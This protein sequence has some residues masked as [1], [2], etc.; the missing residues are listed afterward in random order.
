MTQ[1]FCLC[2]DGAFLVRNSSMNTISEPLVLAIYYKKKVYNIKIRF[3]EDSNKYALGTG[4][5]SKDV[6]VQD[7]ALQDFTSFLNRNSHNAFKVAHNA[8]GGFQYSQKC[9][10]PSHPPLPPLPQFSS[11]SSN[12]I[13]SCFK[14][15]VLMSRSS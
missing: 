1:V 3:S 6:S 2:Q 15:A 9:V 13:D 10:T 5:H 4:L 7:S 8:L 14:S 11:E 12:L